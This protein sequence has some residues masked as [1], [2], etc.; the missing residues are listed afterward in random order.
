MKYWQQTSQPTGI[1]WLALD[2]PNQR[3][4]TLNHEVISELDNLLNRLEMNPPKALILH[5]KKSNGFI[6]GADVEDFVKPKQ[7][8][9]VQRLIEH[10]HRVFQRLEDFSAITIASINH[11]CLGGGLELALACDYRIVD[12]ELQT[13]LG[14]PEIK[15]GIFPGFGGTVRSI[16]KIGMTNAMQLML[17][18]RLVNGRQ[19]LKLGLV[20]ACVPARQLVNA[21]LALIQKPP[22]LAK[23]HWQQQ[24]L[25]HPLVLPL[26]EYWFK[27]QIK[28]HV[29]PDHYPAPFRL[30]EHCVK[31]LGSTQA[32]YDS[33][34]KQVSQLLMGD[35]A[36][37]LVRVF[38]LQQSLKRLAPEGI[39][40][41]KQVHV[42]GAGVMGGDIAAWCALQGITVTLQD[43]SPELLAKAY[44][45]AHTMFKQK[46]KQKHLINAALDRLIPDHTGQAVAQADVVIEAIYENLEAKQALY[47]EIESRLKPNA[48]FAS[49]TSSIPLEQLAEKLKDPSR[50]IGLHFFNPVARMQLIEIIKSP[51]TDKKWVEQGLAFIR[52]IQRLGLPVNSCPGFLVNRILMPYLMQAVMLLQEG[53]PARIID[54]AA[55]DFGMPMGPIAL[56]DTV[57]LDICLAVADKL[58][59]P[60]GIEIP[61]LLNNTVAE[62]KLGR[63]TQQ[64]FYRYNNQGKPIVEKTRLGKIPEGLA[65]QLI[66]PLL[67]EAVSC[68]RE[69]VVEDMDLLDAGVIF[70][71]GFAPFL[72]GPLKAI[73]QSKKPQLRQR[74]KHLED[75]SHHHFHA[76][77]G[78]ALLEV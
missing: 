9:Q 52:Q 72:G 7:S 35:V 55:K 4:N 56:A 39:A 46:L 51:N 57:G 19:A 15:L 21:T 50:L 31:N 38:F 77:S 68:L 74:L 6:A 49:N 30:I 3:L 43:R 44:Q 45:R 41:K 13:R 47:A 60:L 36:Q 71:T 48:L 26:L 62:G 42:I 75:K 66:L 18:T 65:D 11:L 78:W 37:N 69:K 28:K 1:I 63:K 73:R 17:S 10:A 40:P 16:E 25:T 58:A 33:E 27:R 14:F 61:A 24:W 20:D 70:G 67:N 5:S 29:N 2:V 76:D 32:M 12:D 53:V 23:A 54:Q 64:G 59:E 22:P 34:A 8:F